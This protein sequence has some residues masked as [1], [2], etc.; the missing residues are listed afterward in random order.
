MCCLITLCDNAC[1][2]VAFKSLDRMYWSIA[3]QAISSCNIIM[4]PNNKLWRQ[5][6]RATNTDQKNISQRTTRP[7]L[8]SQVIL[9]IVLVLCCS[10]WS[11]FFIYRYHRSICCST[12]SPWLHRVNQGP[13]DF[14]RQH[15]SWMS[16][17]YLNLQSRS[18]MIKSSMDD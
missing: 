18:E 8:E 10:K 15:G 16:S 17:I 1:T 6:Y 14:L 4:S 3:I 5:S 13:G 7:V 2:A 9:F 11:L 12:S